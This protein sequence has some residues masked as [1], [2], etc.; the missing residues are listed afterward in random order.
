MS[1]LLTCIHRSRHLLEKLALYI[2]VKA[3]SYFPMP[4]DLVPG[5]GGPAGCHGAVSDDRTKAPVAA[6]HNTMVETIL[7]VSISSAMP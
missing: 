5:I 6:A 2:H 3:D 4:G 1:L 7:T